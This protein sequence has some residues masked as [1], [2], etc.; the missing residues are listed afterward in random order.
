MAHDSVF[1]SWRYTL[2]PDK[3]NKWFYENALQLTSNVIS[4]FGSALFSVEAGAGFALTRVRSVGSPIG[5]IDKALFQ[6]VYPKLHVRTEKHIA[7]PLEGEFPVF[8]ARIPFKTWN[9]ADNPILYV[10]EIRAE[11]DPLSTVYQAFG[12]LRDEEVASFNLFVQKRDRPLFHKASKTYRAVQKIRE[13]QDRKTYARRKSS[14]EKIREG[15]IFNSWYE[16]FITLEIFGFSHK[17][18]VELVQVMTP[19]F[20]NFKRDVP[21]EPANGLQEWFDGIS[22]VEL[23]TVDE[24]ISNSN[25]SL[26][27][28][29]LN[30][31]KTA[32]KYMDGFKTYLSEREIAS[33]WHIPHKSFS[34]LNVEWIP[35][36]PQAPD[37]LVENDEGTLFGGAFHDWEMKPIRILAQDRAQHINI[38]GRNGTGKSTLIHNLIRSDIEDGKGVCV[39]DPHGKLIQDILRTSIPEDREDDVV[40]LDFSQNDYPVPLNIFATDAEHTAI[41]RIVD[42]IEK[43]S[44]DTPTGIRTAKYLRESIRLL[45]YHPNATMLDIVP[46]FNDDEFRQNLLDVLPKT[47]FTIRS[48]WE[49]QYANLSSGEKSKLLEPILSRIEPFIGNDYLFPMLCHPQCVD[50]ADHIDKKRIILVNLSVK[51][52]LVPEKERNLIGAM[53][54]S[55]L[56]F[57]GMREYESTSEGR[58]EPVFYSYVD[59][60]QHFVTTSLDTIFSEARKYGLSMTV[61]NQYLGQ[62]DISTMKAVMSNVGT[63]VCFRCGIDDGRALSPYMEPGFDV[64]KLVNLDMYQAA[65]KMQLRGKTM[66][67][68]LLFPFP[69]EGVSDDAD[70]REKRIREKSYQN[71]LPMTNDDVLNW[72][73]NRNKPPKDDTNDDTDEDDDNLQGEFIN[74][75]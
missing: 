13:E 25:L 58:P 17:R 46:L 45:Q 72:I 32:N 54:I 51:G 53:I 19:A 14:E 60:V 44:S 66:D 73:M 59:E 75:S 56:Q 39:I 9:I 4:T 5:K 28:A 65:V 36:T 29:H 27:Y 3:E 20:E 40:L 30:N 68:F 26:L 16:C 49:L 37:S 21:G 24:V 1:D 74:K 63:T 62:L 43:I 67:S 35:D 7:L 18:V 70:V 22:I 23:E 2:Y 42:M 11:T 8:L 12:A 41:G 52:G 31:D 71:F 6:N 15:K 33:L 34:A 10:D 69:P 38:L 64:N 55:L 61:A 48:F 50:F 57:V 47:A